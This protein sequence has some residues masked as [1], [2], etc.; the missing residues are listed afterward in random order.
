M[1]FIT[2]FF[3][4]ICRLIWNINCGWIETYQAFQF[5]DHQQFSF[6]TFLSVVTE[7]HFSCH[8]YFLPFLRLPNFVLVCVAWIKNVNFYSLIFYFQSLIWIAISLFLYFRFKKIL[9]CNSFSHCLEYFYPH[10]FETTR[11]NTF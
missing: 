4:K 2:L 9:R 8:H 3:R 5:L 1:L 6:L 11:I 10:Y 7:K